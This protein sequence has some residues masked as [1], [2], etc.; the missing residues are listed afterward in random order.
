M[1]PKQP[2]VIP[3][4]PVVKSPEIVPQSTKTTVKEKVEVKKSKPILSHSSSSSSSH[5][6]HSHHSEDDDDDDE[7]VFYD[8]LEM[9]M[10]DRKGQRV[11]YSRIVTSSTF[12]KMR[13]HRDDL[14]IT[15]K[16]LHHRNHQIFINVTRLQELIHNEGKR[17]ENDPFIKYVSNLDESHFINDIQFDKVLL[18]SDIM[19]GIKR[20]SSSMEINQPSKKQEITTTAVTP[21]SSPVVTPVI[22]V[23]PVTP[24]KSKIPITPSTPTK[25]TKSKKVATPVTPTKSKTIATPVTP[26]K[27]KTIATPVTPTKSP[28]SPKSPKSIKSLKSIK[29]IKSPR[30]LKSTPSK[31]SMQSSSSIQSILE[32]IEDLQEELI[33]KEWEFHPSSDS[34]YYNYQS[35]FPPPDKP[36]SNEISCDDP[37]PSTPI[38]PSSP[39]VILYFDFLIFRIRS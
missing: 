39:L 21:P 8:D 6:H 3:Q 15:S 7:E 17:V 23:T 29:S 9:E 36:Q 13:V 22:P 30:L 32:A 20:A 33:F 34:R 18:A 38:S 2:A 11:N 12:N 4:Q 28:K 5:H 1:I 26:T 37:L 19:R 10:R 16:K 24:T 14:I 35:L 25:S 27:S 31:P